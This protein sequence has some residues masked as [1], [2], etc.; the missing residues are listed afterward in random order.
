MF[1]NAFKVHLMVKLR[2]SSLEK[3]ELDRFLQ[4]IEPFVKKIKVLAPDKSKYYRAYIELKHTL[5]NPDKSSSI[6]END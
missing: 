5:T 1:E 3:N 4:S 6:N 2:A